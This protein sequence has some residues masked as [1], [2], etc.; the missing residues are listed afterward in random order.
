MLSLTKPVSVLLGLSVV[1]SCGCGGGDAR[2]PTASA[3]SRHIAALVA[4]GE[5][6]VIAR[7]AGMDRVSL[8]LHRLN[9]DIQVAEIPAG[10][11]FVARRAAVHSMVSTVARTISVAGDGWIFVDIPAATIEPRRARSVS[12]DTFEIRPEPA[13][14][15]LR[16]LI[17]ILAAEERTY[18]VRQAAVW[19]VAADASYDQLQRIVVGDALNAVRV[20][21]ELAM[22]EALEICDRAGID[23]TQKA[24]WREVD[25]I[26]RSLA[27][28]PGGEWLRR[29]IGSRRSTG[30]LT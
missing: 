15:E 5:L 23:V 10:T 7:G 19:I 12:G 26:D 25:S 2:D 8:E 4:R 9:K 29:K 27:D 30:V 11:F 28:A 24:I 16:R 18:A 17:P 1:V 14:D 20:I 13:G 21:D 22:A 3:A 6:D